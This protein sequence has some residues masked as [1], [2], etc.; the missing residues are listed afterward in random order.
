MLHCV[1]DS[2][3][4]NQIVFIFKTNA[5][6]VAKAAER[7]NWGVTAVNQEQAD[8]GWF[9][10]TAVNPS[11]ASS[12]VPAAQTT[13]DTQTVQYKRISQAFLTGMRSLNERC[14]YRTRGGLATA[15]DFN[16]AVK[17]VFHQAAL[18]KALEDGNAVASLGQTARRNR[19]D[20][21]EGYITGR[22]VEQFIFF[23]N[24]KT[25]S[26]RWAGISLADGTTI[27][28]DLLTTAG[29]TRTPDG[30]DNYQ[31][32]GSI[33]VKFSPELPALT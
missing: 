20:Y 14:F 2:N 17:W 4:N 26:D 15:T 23:T 12:T 33:P 5:E 3:A 31:G 25:A 21:I 29:A 16:A 9:V 27:S 13:A 7:T 32:G 10:N 1:Y 18:M 19:F 6:A 24:N 11:V 28:T 8:V 30:T 22:A